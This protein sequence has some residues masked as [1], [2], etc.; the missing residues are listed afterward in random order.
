VLAANAQYWIGE[1]YYIQ[2][3]WRQALTEFEKVLAHDP[4]TGKVAEA[5]LRM[6]HC[7][8]NLR[9]PGRA[10]QAWQRVIAEHPRSAAARRARG[11]MDGAR[12]PSRR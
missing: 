6:G 2:R 4:Y 8:R 11:L 10:Q 9:E 3:D 7:H 12:G 5:L 1:A